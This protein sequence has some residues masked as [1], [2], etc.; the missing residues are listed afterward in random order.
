M[1][2]NAN[3]KA[4]ITYEKSYPTASAQYG[5]LFI[6]N[7]GYDNYKYVLHD[8]YSD[9]FSLYN[10]DHSLFK[11]VQIPITTDSCMRYSIG[12]ISSELFDCDSSTIEYVLLPEAPIYP[13]RIYRTDGTMLFFKDSVYGWWCYGCQ[14]ASTEIRTIENTPAGTKMFLHSPW[15]L[16]PDSVFVYGLCGTLPVNISEI[17]QSN[18]IVKIFPNPSTSQINF[19]IIV[20]INIEEYEL[21]IFNSAFQSVKIYIVKETNARINL[22]TESL[23]SG[24]YFYSLK[25]RSKIFQTGKFIISN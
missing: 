1:L 18:S 21:T 8:C 2:S 5:Y 10:L 14:E 25:S 11:N 4:Q 13:F 24:T 23:S 9:Q 19:E 7:L 15:G 12:F 6:T 20:P 16:G 22:S 17:N 3:V